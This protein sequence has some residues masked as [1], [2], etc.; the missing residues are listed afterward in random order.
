MPLHRR[1][2][3]PLSHFL[4]V[5]LKIQRYR[6]HAISLMGRWRPIIE[7]MTQMRSATGTK[8]F[9]PVHTIRMV[10]PIRHAVLPGRL[11]KAGPSTGTRELRVTPEQPVSANRTKIGTFRILV[12][13]LSGKCPLRSLLPCCS[14]KCR[15]Q[16]LFPFRIGYFQLIRI[17][18]R[19]IWI[20]PVSVF[21]CKMLRK[22]T[23]RN[24]NGQHRCYDK[25]P[26]DA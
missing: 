3:S 14:I 24:G 6:I 17:R 7:N 15:R 2:V 25:R 4:F 8:D 9:D 26:H 21:G 23:G 22:N 12:Q 13:I 11:K 20:V 10:F 1:P 16:Y 18:V 19:I 5:R